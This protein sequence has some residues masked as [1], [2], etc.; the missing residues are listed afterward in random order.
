MWRYGCRT[1]QYGLDNEGRCD[2][3]GGRGCQDVPQMHDPGFGTFNFA[4][5]AARCGGDAQVSPSSCVNESCHWYWL[6]TRTPDR[7]YE[8][9]DF[10]P[11]ISAF[12]LAMHDLKRHIAKFLQL[13]ERFESQQKFRCPAISELILP[14]SSEVLRTTSDVH[15]ASDFSEKKPWI[16]TWRN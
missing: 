15:G 5:Q 16:G 9:L 4:K 1:Q 2:S 14:A 12:S 10:G 6:I 3:L 8:R 11:N 7:T 13:S